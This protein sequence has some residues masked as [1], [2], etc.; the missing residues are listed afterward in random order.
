MLPNAL[1]LLGAFA[2]AVVAAPA[3]EHVGIEARAVSCKFT[4]LDE[5]LKGKK[6][7]D[8]LT[9]DNIAV[10][11]GKTLDL[12]GLKKGCNLIFKGKT[13]FGY[14]EWEGPLISVSG[15]NVRVE[16][17]AGHTID[18]DG[19]RWWDGKGGN[20]GK[21]KPKLFSAK[22]LNNSVIKGLNVK[23]QPVHG[24]SI[25]TVKNLDIIDV[26]LDSQAGDTQ[27]G[28]NT[29]G[30]NIGNAENIY[31]SGAIVRNQDDC[32]AINSGKNITFTGGDCSGGH[33]LSI[34]SVGN[35]SNNDVLN[36]RITNSVISKSDNGVR[37]KT[38]ADASGRV[39]NILYENITLKDIVK[40]GVVIQQDYENGGPTGKPSG[41][42][43]I[44]NVKLNGVKGNVLE[45]GANVYIL[46]AKGACS[47]WEWKGVDVTGGKKPKSCLNVPS[48]AK[49]S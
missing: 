42:V 32:I 34:G 9:L 38:I 43:P 23:N 28:H 47:G 15:E 40:Q 5:V 48:P 3:S 30:F 14:K 37:I 8:K 12:T 49:C 2:S 39:D 4:T 31:I 22:N 10:P 17:T 24:F 46:C 35:R 25:N 18:C 27:G 19:K 21:T 20:G 36:V 26:T 11:A 7:C 16:G 6:T 45:K 29:D 33:G 13:T 1:L 41:G 44:T